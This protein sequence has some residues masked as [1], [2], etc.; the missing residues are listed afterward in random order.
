MRNRKN[1]ISM[2]ATQNPTDKYVV[3][4]D[5][6]FCYANSK[7]EAELMRRLSIYAG[8]ET[9]ESVENR[10]EKEYEVRLEQSYFRGQLI[11]AILELCEQ[12]G[13][14]KG[15]I[16]AIKIALENSQVEL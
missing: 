1:T 8:Q 6:F 12:P 3:A 4:I 5:G 16:G 10:L 11:E 15:L 7:T 9:P 2:F 14:K 13:T